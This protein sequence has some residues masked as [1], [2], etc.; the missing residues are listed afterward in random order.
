[1]RSSGRW[2]FLLLVLVLAAS[3]AAAH[4]GR[5]FQVQVRN[6]QLVAQGYIT[7]GVADDGGGTTRP[8]LNA[9][10]DH[11]ANLGDAS[12]VS[13]LPGFDVLDTTV[14]EGFDL[15][16]VFVDAFQWSNPPTDPAANLAPRFLNLDSTI[17][18]EFGAT[19]DT[20]DGGSLPLANN[21]P[22]AGLR[23]L[24]PLYAISGTPSDVIHVL[25]WQLTTD[26]PGVADSDSI[27]TILSPDGVGPVERLHEASLLTERFLGQ[28]VPEP[29]AFATTLGGFLLAFA[30]AGRRFRRSGYISRAKC[31][32]CD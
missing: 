26:A 27:Y 3:P 25:E 17:G 29:S 13:N 31:I 32:R 23:D 1:M 10:H 22:P 14:L 4:N 30:A 18:I 24:D 11:W 16:L 15:S 12:A 7:A 28:A 20:I 8:Y 6:Q 9:I 21:I 2:W 5:R 19:I